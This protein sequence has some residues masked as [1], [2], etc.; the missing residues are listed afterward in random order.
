MKRLKD[1]GIKIIVF[2]PALKENKFFNSTVIKNLDEF[3][4]LS[5]V[6]VANRM[7]GELNDVKDKIYTR[8]LFNSD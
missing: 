3:K 8:D 6:I 7:V 4:K 5:G 2:E 1:K